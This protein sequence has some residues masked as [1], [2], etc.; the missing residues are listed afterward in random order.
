MRNDRRQTAVLPPMNDVESRGVEL[1]VVPW[2]VSN[3]RVVGEFEHI[4]VDRR[5]LSATM[6]LLFFLD[7]REG[8]PT[9]GERGSFSRFPTAQLDR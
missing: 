2:I 8:V 5:V 6:V 4:K 1:S 9:I 3:I 7:L